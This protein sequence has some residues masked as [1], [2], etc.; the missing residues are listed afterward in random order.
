MLRNIA[1]KLWFVSAIY[2]IIYI[3]TSFKQFI[4]QHSWTAVIHVLFAF[5]FFIGVF[6]QIVRLFQYLFNKRED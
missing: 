3:L 2:F 4:N 5:I 6:S 1:I